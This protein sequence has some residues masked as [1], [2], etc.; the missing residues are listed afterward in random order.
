MTYFTHEGWPQLLQEKVAERKL[1]LAATPVHATNARYI[2]LLRSLW[3]QAYH[4]L[5]PCL[6]AIEIS[7]G[8]GW[9]VCLLQNASA[10]HACVCCIWAACVMHAC[11][12]SR[13]HVSCTHI[14]LISPEGGWNRCHSFIHTWTTPCMPTH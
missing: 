10:S 14:H 3:G 6:W 11:A 2:A 13:L 8:L 9:Q 4:V 1:H 5:A 7:Y 12:A